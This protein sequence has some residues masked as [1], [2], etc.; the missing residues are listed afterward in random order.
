LDFG[1]EVCLEAMR[2]R[3]RR[4][5]KE[6]RRKVDLRFRQPDRIHLDRRWASML[7]GKRF[8]ERV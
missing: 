8:S 3:V 2:R 1:F 6:R 4:R 5:S 7:C